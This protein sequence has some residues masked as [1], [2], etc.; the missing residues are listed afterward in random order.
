M[1][2]DPTRSA[3]ASRFLRVVRESGWTGAARRGIGRLLQS[4]AARLDDLGVRVAL[5]APM[6]ALTSAAWRRQLGR[7]R[8][9]RDKH[10]GRTCLIAGNGPSVLTQDLSGLEGVIVFA[11][12]EALYWMEKSGLRP[13]YYVLVDKAYLDPAY[14]AFRTD[15][16]DYLQAN[17]VTL[18]ADGEFAGCRELADV[19]AY[20]V[21]S[22]MRSRNYESRGR[23]ISIDLTAAVPGFETVVHAAIA[24][25]IFMGF[26]TIILVGCEHD[27]FAFPTEAR[28]HAHSANVEDDEPAS[29]MQLFSEDQVELLH[30]AHAEFLSFKGLG[31]IAAANGQV[32]L[33]ATAGGLLEVFPRVELAE[34]A[35]PPRSPA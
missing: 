6:S 23:R 15:L 11:V 30:R 17:A 9:L 13:T 20:W 28:R 22:I 7:N 16:R 5:D 26:K 1:V 14:S 32:I 29:P 35:R 34:L 18:V 33:N 25:A 27:Y 24:A 2:F 8:V 3:G 31:D 19:D 21:A 12:N 4:A 10:L